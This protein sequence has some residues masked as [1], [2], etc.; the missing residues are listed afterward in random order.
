[1]AQ[2]TYV[3]KNTACKRECYRVGVIPTADVIAHLL[4]LDNPYYISFRGYSFCS[5]YNDIDMVKLFLN[6]IE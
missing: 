1:M 3:C 2:N 4:R 5:E 6:S